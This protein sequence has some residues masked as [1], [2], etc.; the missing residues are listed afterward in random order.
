M[1]IAYVTPSP[2][3][4][5]AAVPDHFQP[6]YIQDLR[7]GRVARYHCTVRT[8]TLTGQIRQCSAVG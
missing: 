2:R 3:P 7:E 1:F 6:V 4:Q 8:R 5:R